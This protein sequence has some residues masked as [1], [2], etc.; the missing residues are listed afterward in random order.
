MSKKIIAKTVV[1]LTT[2]VLLSGCFGLIWNKNNIVSIETVELSNNVLTLNASS[3][4]SIS[5]MCLSKDGLKVETQKVTWSIADTSVASITSSNDTTAVF[6]SLK[7]GT[8]SITATSVENNKV[9]AVGEIRIVDGA[10]PTK[11]A[12]VDTYKDYAAHSYDRISTAPTTGSAKALIIPIWF[13]DSSSYIT[14][15]NNVREDIEKAY[16]GSEIETGWHSVKS[17]YERESRGKLTFEGQVSD[18]FECGQASTSYYV[19]DNKA[20]K[21]QGLIN[22]AFAWYKQKYGTENLKDFD[23]DGDGYVDAL[24]LIYAAPD[25]SVYPNNNDNMW[26]YC[27]WTQNEP[28][29]AQPN[30]NVFFWA[31]YDFMYDST[32]SR[33]RAGKEFGGGDCSHL[34]VDAHTYIHEMGHV[35]GLADYYDYSSHQYK[36]AGGFSMQDFNVGSHDPYSR[37]ALGWDNP[38]VPTESTTIHI[39]PYQSSGDLILLSSH[40]ETFTYSSFDEYLL[41]ELYTP[42]GLNKFDTTYVYNGGYPYGTKASGI[43]IWHVDARLIDLTDYHTPNPITEDMITVG[44]KD[45]HIYTQAMSNTYYENGGSNDYITILGKNYADYNI[46]H[47]LRNKTTATYKNNDLFCEATLFKSGSLFSMSYYSSQ[48]KKSALLN[49]GSVLGWEVEFKNVSV[50]GADVTLKRL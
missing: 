20:T 3:S 14:N 8:T 40:P 11:T 17:F 13:T 38:Y 9:Y 50:F 27:Y 22:K 43:R 15:R 46:L 16:L 5:A 36:P 25:S 24:M 23:R 30:I 10:V 21:T 49:D 34:S 47:L 39:N 28:S 41:I 19:D 45:N 31:S 6:N 7:V 48:F 37:M 32:M 4:G 42:T 2:P 26:A 29:V 1:I 33:K 35:F 18:W 12:L 44:M